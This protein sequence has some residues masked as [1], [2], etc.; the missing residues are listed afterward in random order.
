MQNHVIVHVFSFLLL[1]FSY[2]YINEQKLTMGRMNELLDRW[3][4][5]IETYKFE[6]EMRLGYQVNRR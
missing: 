1:C 6:E 3:Q 4:K 2:S 5:Q